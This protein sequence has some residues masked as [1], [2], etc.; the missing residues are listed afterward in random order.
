MSQLPLQGQT[1][2][3]VTPKHQNSVYRRRE[4]ICIQNVITF[5]K[6]NSESIKIR[7][8]TEAWNHTA[9]GK[10]NS[11]GSLALRLSQQIQTNLTTEAPC[12]QKCAITQK[13]DWLFFLSTTTKNS[14]ELIQRFFLP[15]PKYSHSYNEMASNE[16]YPCARWAQPKSKPESNW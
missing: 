15:R 3:S 2:T 13:L 16:A 10:C 6:I 1:T 8:T 7:R 11:V 4:E 14:N 9:L 5:L 12:S